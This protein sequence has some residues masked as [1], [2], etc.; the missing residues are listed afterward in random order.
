MALVSLGQDGE[1]SCVFFR[2]GPADLFYESCM[3]PEDKLEEALVF[4]ARCGAYTAMHFGAFDA[5]PTP[6]NLQ[7]L[8]PETI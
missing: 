1:R 2:T 5:L 3:C 4:A 7:R 6:G 8:V